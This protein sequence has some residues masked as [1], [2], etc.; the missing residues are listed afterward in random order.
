METERPFMPVMIHR[1]G[2]EITQRS[3]GGVFLCAPLSPRRA[4]A[5]NIP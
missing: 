5:V 1:R 4:S 2:A 3:R